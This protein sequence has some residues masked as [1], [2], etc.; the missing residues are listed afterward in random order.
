MKQVVQQYSNG[1]LQVVEVP[2]PQLQA[3]RVLVK[4]T[5]SLISAGTEKTKVALARKNLLGKASSRPELVKKAIAK[6]KQEGWWRTWR[7]VSLR[8]NRPIALGYSSSGVVI[9]VAEG[10]A[11]LRPGD[12]VA[13]AGDF[14]NHAEII[15]VPQNLVVGVPEGVRLDHAAFATLGAIAMQSVRQAEV[16]LGE[17]VAVIGLGLIGL[18][19]V[20][21][22]KTAGCQVMGIEINP[23]NLAMGRKLGC[24]Q[25]VWANE[26]SLVEKVHAF[27]MGYLVDATIIA[28]GTPSNRPIEL[29]GEITREKGR[30]VV[31][32]AVRMDIPREPFYLKEIDLRLARSYGPGRYDKNYEERGHDYPFAYVRFTE[33]RNMQCFL[34]LV[35][36]KAIDLEAMITHR[37][38]I[39]EAAC[40]YELLRNNSRKQYLGILLEYTKEI[41]QIPQRIELRPE[42]RHEKIVVSVIGAGNYAAAHLLPHLQSNP[43][44][45]LGTL[46]TATGVTAFQTGKKAGFQY[47]DSDVD[48]LISES[49]AILIATRHH[50]HATYAARA[51]QL[52]KPVFVEKPLALNQKEL[53]TIARLAGNGSNNLVMVGFNRRFSTAVEM[54]KA[55]FTPKQEPMQV[56]V[57]VNAGPIPHDHW[58][59]DAEIGGG[60]L[61]GEA[62]HFVDLVVALTGATVVAVSTV[63]IPR[64]NRLPALWD[65][66]CLALSMCDGS[67]GTVVY[68]SR[69]DTGLFKEHIEVFGGGRTAVIRDFKE[70]ELWCGGKNKLKKW[71]HPDKGQKRQ[72]EAWIRGLQCG[73]SPIPISQTLNVHQ[74]CLAALRS[75]HKGESIRLSQ[76][77]E[78]M[79]T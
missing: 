79:P 72:M 54:V 76:T 65:D 27:T 51:L 35:R 47:L 55:H 50:D 48:R 21:I 34:E 10:V 30:V 29:A 75:M 3:G 56:L 77:R 12:R 31:L 70:V 58:I 20:Q 15:A 41:S 36:D 71:R 73:E 4:T 8:L 37:F 40:A 16:R 18:L 67:V 60:R 32:G 59:Q 46:C 52:G 44:V 61:L 43:A 28:A 42:A 53:D 25:A 68:S 78:F 14:A 22:L 24:Q 38:P 39:A 57:R 19:V 66:F 5:Y 26:R 23:Q 1:A 7:N 13:C 9:D 17:K 49:D 45:C 6:A 62:C 69:G 74:A 2:P 64:A 33:Q 11:G 63:A